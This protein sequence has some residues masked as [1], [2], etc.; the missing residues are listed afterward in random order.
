MAKIEM[1]HTHE[2]GYF[3]TAVHNVEADF[4]IGYGGQ[5]KPNDNLTLRLEGAFFDGPTDTHFGRWEE[6]D[7]LRFRTIYKF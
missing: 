7:F 2:W 4:S 5:Y 6:N 1:E 3:L